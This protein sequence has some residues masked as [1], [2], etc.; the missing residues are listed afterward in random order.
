MTAAVRG[1]RTSVVG[2]HL[3]SS[4]R[5]RAEGASAALRAHPSCW[6]VVV[7]YRGEV[8]YCGIKQVVREMVMAVVLRLAD[9]EVLL[10]AMR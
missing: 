2:A 7:F 1:R 8:R 3:G 4:L 10:L 6:W 5:R 9:D